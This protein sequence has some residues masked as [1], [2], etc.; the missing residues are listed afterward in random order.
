MP[1]RWTLL[2]ATAEERT[3]FATLQ[4]T[5]GLPSKPAAP[6]NRFRAVTRIDILGQTYFL[7]TFQH[8]QLKNRLRNR[9]TTPRCHLDAEREAAVA[10][11]LESQ[12]IEVARPIAVG[13]EAGISYYV[14]AAIDGKC[15][16]E[17][18]STGDWPADRDRELATF[19]GS[20]AARGIVLTDL[21]ADHCFVTPRGFAV[22]DLHNGRQRP[23]PTKRE[24]VRMLRRFAKSVRELSIDRFRALRFAVRLLRH[25][26]LRHSARS[27]VR[28][29][30]PFDTHGRYDAVTRSSRYRDRNPRRTAKEL[31]LLASVWPGAPTDI[32][33]DS[34]CG[35]GRLRE[36]ILSTGAKWTG[37]DRSASM[38]AEVRARYPD[39]LILHCD[40]TSLPLDDRCVA[41]T[42][43]FR[44]L[45]HLDA[46]TAE[47]VVREATRVAANFV[48]ISFFHP[49]SAHNLKRRAKQLFL[50][51]ARHP[52]H[53]ETE[54]TTTL[55]NVRRIRQRPIYR[56]TTLPSRPLD[57]SVQT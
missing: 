10:E 12:G 42:V 15:I 55:A 27:I 3:V 18:R 47:Q 1:N 38:L 49:I 22:I 6:P 13:R 56:R 4:M 14:C 25:S 23:S 21:S 29:L 46:S 20:I 50:R 36:F 44:L 26:S 34:P 33:L 48:V 19:C 5:L 11:A 30:P 32:V 53:P 45:H 24:A 43:V 8:T 40:A 9:C 37:A 39:A 28:R 17:L 51:T 7:K 57:R 16:A 54:T 35:A 31:A 41:G 2:N 52:F